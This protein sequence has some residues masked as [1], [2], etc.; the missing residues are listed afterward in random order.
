MS[1]LTKTKMSNYMA[2]LSHVSISIDT[3]EEEVRTQAIGQDSHVQ[4]SDK[5]CNT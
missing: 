2:Q 5:H 4:T 1:E 3:Q